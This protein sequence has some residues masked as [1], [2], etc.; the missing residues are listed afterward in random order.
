MRLAFVQ[1][2]SLIAREPPITERPCGASIVATSIPTN[3]HDRRSERRFAV[4]HQT[5]IIGDRVYVWTNGVLID[6]EGAEVAAVEHRSTQDGQHWLV[7]W[8]DGGDKQL[9]SAAEAR[10]H[11][12]RVLGGRTS[13]AHGE[14]RETATT[15]NASNVEKYRAPAPGRDRRDVG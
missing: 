8:P 15:S 3:D 1:M 11:I 10:E 5:L 6:A 14:G 12:E 9:A 4:E 7:T 13:S 2:P